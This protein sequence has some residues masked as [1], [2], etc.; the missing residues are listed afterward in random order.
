LGIA[1][2]VARAAFV[3]AISSYGRSQLYRWVKHHHWPKIKVIHC[4]IDEAFHQTVV[5]QPPANVPRFVTVGRLTAAKGHLLLLEAAH[6]LARRGVRLELVFVGDGEM[7]ADL[8]RFV[9]DH[10]LGSCV[11]I[12]GAISTDELRRELLESR[13]LILASFAEGLPMVIMEAMALRRPVLT[14]YV[15]GIPELVR[16]GENGWLFPAGSID[17]LVAAIEDCLSRSTEDVTAMGEAC[18]ARVLARHSVD[19]QAAKLAEN[20][21]R[22]AQTPAA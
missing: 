14:T 15:A 17:A 5:A 12:A 22:S 3:V 11:R 16:P 21:R 6:C 8:E 7:R 20:F 1:E 19:V 13:G 18:R 9:A 2:K 4:G 10:D